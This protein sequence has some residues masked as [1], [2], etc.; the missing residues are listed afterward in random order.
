MSALQVGGALQAGKLYIERAADLRL[1]ELLEAGRYAVVFAPRQ[2]GKSSLRRRVQ[3]Q[4]RAAGRRAFTLDLLAAGRDD[5][6]RWYRNLIEALAQALGAPRPGPF[7]KEHEDLSPAG[8]VWLYLRQAVEAEPSPFTLF[9]DEVDAVTQVPGLDADAFFQGLKVVRDAAA[10]DPVWARFTCCLLGVVTERDLVRDPALAPSNA[11]FASIDLADFSRPE[12][13]ALAPHLQGL[14]ASP[15]ALID[16]LFEA[17][18]GHPYQSLRLALA[19]IEAAPQPGLCAADQVAAQVDELFVQHGL[20]R[21]ASLYWPRGFIERLP[22]QRRDE[23]LELYRRALLGTR[24]RWRGTVD[25]HADLRVAGLIRLDADGRLS[26]RSRIFAE[27]LGLDWVNQLLGGRA[28][29]HALTAWEKSGRSDEKLLSAEELRAARAWL[30]QQPHPT[31]SMR[32]LVTASARHLEARLAQAVEEERARAKARELELMNEKLG[33]AEAAHREAEARSDREAVEARHAEM[34][35]RLERAQSHHRMQVQR[36]AMGMLV[37]AVLAGLSVAWRESKAALQATSERDE[38]DRQLAALRRSA[39][40]V[41][42]DLAADIEETKRKVAE[43]DWAL[44]NKQAELAAAVADQKAHQRLIAER[45]ELLAERR[46]GEAE[47]ARLTA[48]AAAQQAAHAKTISQ[49][50]S[51]TDVGTQMRAA[52]DDCVAREQ[53]LRSTQQE[54][55]AQVEAYEDATGS[56]PLV[57]PPSLGRAAEPR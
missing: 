38:L 57:A 9:I 42:E 34:T 32:A 17:A 54:L 13:G 14:G 4:L 40:L 7:W 16:A 21:E 37:V 18:A 11:G 25:A 46:D 45:D 22:A 49:V 28:F 52:L 6:S 41:Q 30:A 3:E 43:Q 2:T 50:A 48:E 27:V 10:S 33:R 36:F 26:P 23:A 5:P 31:Q 53:R 56:L 1:R 12:L 15:E 51:L 20:L 55:N 47:L 29:D 44:R 8:R 39:A 35:L 24:P 19:L